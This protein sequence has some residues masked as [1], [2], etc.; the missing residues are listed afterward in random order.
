M[1][2]AR[3]FKDRILRCRKFV[4]DDG[5]MLDEL[6]TVLEREFNSIRDK[7][8]FIMDSLIETLEGL[9]AMKKNFEELPGLYNFDYKETLD[10]TV[11]QR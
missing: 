4:Q 2:K 11:K 9:R 6:L 5:D 3:K 7:Q 8:P 10:D 1:V